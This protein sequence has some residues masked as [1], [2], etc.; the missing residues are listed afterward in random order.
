MARLHSKLLYGKPGCD[1]RLSCGLRHF[2]QN[3]LAGNSELGPWELL[4]AAAS[5]SLWL[6]MAN[7]SHWKLWVAVP[8]DGQYKTN[9][10][11]ACQRITPMGR[12]LSATALES[13]AGTSHEDTATA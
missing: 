7:R 8:V 13:Q 6:A 3:P 9:C 12:R 4:E 10:H 2:L 11:M 1:S 5:T